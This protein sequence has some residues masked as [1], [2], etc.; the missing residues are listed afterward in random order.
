MLV[1]IFL[2]SMAAPVMAATD[3]SY[4][5]TYTISMQDDGSANW[6]VD[7]RT[8]LATD[9]DVTTF[10]EYARQIDTVYL[11]Q[12]REI[13]EHSASQAAA[14]TGR[15]MAI[16]NFSGTA[17]IQT[18]PTGRYGV[19]LY[20]FTWTGFARPDTDLSVGD[21]FAGG[22]YLPKDATLI[23]RAP[24]G[25]TVKTALP[26]PDQTYNG[27]TWFGLRSFGTG[28]PHVVFERTALPILWIVAGLLVIAGIV[29]AGVIM[30]RSRENSKIDDDPAPDQTPLSEAEILSLKERILQL[31]RAHGGEMF[32]SE[33]VKQ[34][35][36]PKSTISSA[37]NDLHTEE[38]I[39]K[40]RK[41]RENLIRL[42]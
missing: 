42:R 5:I 17:V 14:A 6:Q 9:D 19:I 31:I 26:E 10:N 40:V 34:S 8:L 36:L 39:V 13:M 32:Q 37:L 22:M 41:G 4:T 30:Y 16:N 28:E 24:V 38:L 3:P 12:I 7:Y 1:A 33:I 23:I 20:T 15:Y 18:A 25:Y 35:G 11:P 2:G 21:A 27:L 29:I